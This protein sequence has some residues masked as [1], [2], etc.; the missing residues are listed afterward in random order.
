MQKNFN[1]LGKEIIK[2]N[3]YLSLATS[4]ENSPWISPLF[5]AIDNKFT[6]YFISQESST[7]IRN[8]FVNNVVAFCIFDSKQ[9]EGT[10]NGVQGKGRVYKLEDDEI[11]TAFLWYKTSFIEL[12]KESFTGDA[13]YRF[14][15]LVPEQVFVL[16]PEAKVDKR[17]EFFLN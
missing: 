8:I 3:I 5:Y 13:P 9:L 4:V 14:Y 17:V 16:D 7:H 12:K 1:E 15:K 11:E 2:S 6:F 10:G